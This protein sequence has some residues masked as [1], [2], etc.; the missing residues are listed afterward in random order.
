VETRWL[1]DFCALA[2][3]RHFSRAAEEQNITQP[4]FSRRI[5]LLEDEMGTLLVDRETM[6]LSLTPAGEMFLEMCE[7]I[8]LLLKTA[9]EECHVQE[10]VEAQKIHF[11]TTQS[12]YLSFYRSW[13]K[14]L[15]TEVDLNINLKSA[16]WISKQLILELEQGHCDLIVCYWSLGNDLLKALDAGEYEFLTV[17]TETLVPVTAVDDEGEPLYILPGSKRL[18]LPYISYNEQTVLHRAINNHL[19]GDVKSAQL[20]VVSESGQATSV[21]AMVAEGF[22]LGWLP[23]RMLAFDSNAR[24]AIAGGSQWTIPIEIRVYKSTKNTH[25]QLATLWNDIKKAFS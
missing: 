19:N 18:P 21:N 3:T 13:V 9:K 4:T 5:K 16:S 15:N 2:R 11:A 6:P 8:T 23:K 1:D 20:L 17:A 12:L 10:Q 7:K 14:E 25:P 22:G 24:L